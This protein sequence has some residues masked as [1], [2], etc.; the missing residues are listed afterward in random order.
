MGELLRFC[1]TSEGSYVILLKI[2]PTV[3]NF[4]GPVEYVIYLGMGGGRGGGHGGPGHGACLHITG[5]VRA[6]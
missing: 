5:N 6:T 2:H 3:Y 4:F 1:W